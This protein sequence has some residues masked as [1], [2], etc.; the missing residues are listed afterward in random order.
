MRKK[1][2]L[3]V[4]PEA[5]RGAYNYNLGDALRVL[6]MGGY[7]ST[8]RFTEGKKH[9]T[10]I[11]AEMA[12][13]YDIVACVGGDGTFSEV[14]GGLMQL[15]DPP[16]I[17]YFP[18]GTSNDVAT[19]LD[20]PKN[21]LIGAAARLVNGSPHGFDVGGFGE[22]E[23]FAYIAAFGAFTA[24]SYE[25]PQSQKKILGHL[26]YVLQGASQLPKIESVHTIV[27]YDE[28]IIED[29]LVYGSLSNSTS[30]A[31][32]VHLRE[33]MVC[34]GDGISE[35][36]LV[37][38]PASVEGYGEIV[39]SVLTRRFD[40]EYLKIVHTKKAKFAFDK[41]VAWTVDGEPGGEHR[42]LSLCNYHS[43]IEFIF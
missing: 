18:M 35:L 26:A 17:G 37:K 34:L 7:T 38:D 10:K 21:D 42:V 15:D 36:V 27:E 9:A 4:N 5:G 13:E 11:T 29:D 12:G 28:G 40:S 41:P 3:I 8:L 22:N 23:Y 19:T 43:P 20:L 1:L 6:D 30:V 31:G 2:L 33:D 32:I 39:T 25:T 24:V 14:L 16:P